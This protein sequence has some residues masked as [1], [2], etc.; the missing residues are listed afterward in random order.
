MISHQE[1]DRVRDVEQ[2]GTPV[3][4]Y[5]QVPNA[6]L[7]LLMADCTGSETKVV[8]YIAR[9]TLGTKKGRE[10]GSDAIALSQFCSGIVK[11][12]GT[13]LD[14]GTG[15]ARAAVVE[16]LYRLEAAG[17]IKRDRGNGRTPDTWRLATELPRTKVQA[18]DKRFRIQTRRGSKSELLAGSK[19]EPAAVE[20]VNGQKK[21]LNHHLERKEKHR[22]PEAA[23]E[24][25]TATVTRKGVLRPFSKNLADDD[26]VKPTDPEDRLKAW[27]RRHGGFS[28]RDWWDL[29][30]A[31]ETK[32]ISLGDLADLAEQNDGR[33][34]SAGA[35]LRWLIQNFCRKTDPVPEEG[36]SAEVAGPCTKCRGL[37]VT[38]WE[39]ER[40]YC[41]SCAMGADVQRADA[42][43]AAER[44]KA[45]AAPA[46]TAV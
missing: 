37:G 4:P 15:L 27:A 45:A 10:K 22:S 3:V 18:P 43:L 21:G 35:G 14:R 19:S 7:D 16:A 5:T 46:Q 29:K 8:L 39:P 28:S 1:A 2:T 11:K 23:V 30:S 32:G 25:S 24:G 34:A 36:G 44:A 20:K 26:Q 41:S 42:R 13:R 12:D 9:R 38:K 17:L 33:W 31:A 40:V 6:F